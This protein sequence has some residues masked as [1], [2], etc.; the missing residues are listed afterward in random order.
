A[1]LAARPVDRGHIDDAVE[2]AAWI[3]AQEAHDRDDVA[4]GGAQRQFVT[5]DR[6][7]ADRRG[8]RISNGPAENFERVFHDQRSIVAVRRIFLCSRSTPY[9]SASAVGGQP[10]T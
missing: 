10:G 8:Q 5:R 6:V 7:A 3:V 2:Q 1:A 4:G 9:S